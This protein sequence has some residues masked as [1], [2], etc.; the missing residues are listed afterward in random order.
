[1]NRGGCRLAES[2]FGTLL[3]CRMPEG[4]A[5]VFEAMNGAPSKA[6]RSS[7]TRRPASA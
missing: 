4:R 1:M 6:V 3:C 5:S 2:L 7:T